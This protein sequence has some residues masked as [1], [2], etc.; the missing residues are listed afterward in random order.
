MFKAIA[1]LAGVFAAPISKVGQR[2]GHGPSIFRMGDEVRKSTSASTRWVAVTT[3]DVPPPGVKTWIFY[4]GGAT[5]IY[6]HGAVA[7][8]VVK[9]LDTKVGGPT[10]MLALVQ[11]P[12]NAITTGTYDQRS[13]VRAVRVNEE[14]MS[15]AFRPVRNLNRLSRKPQMYR[16]DVLRMNPPGCRH[17]NQSHTSA[18]SLGSVQTG[19]A[20]RNPMAATTSFTAPTSVCCYDAETGRLACPASSRVNGM[21]AELID[22]DASTARARVRMPDGRER[23]I[24]ICPS[25]GLAPGSGIPQDCCFDGVTSKVVCS[26]SMELNGQSATVTNE[27]QLDDG[28]RMAVVQLEDGSQLTIPLC[29]PTTQQPPV[30][31][32]VDED[33]MRLVCDDPDHPWNGVDVS[34]VSNC[35]DDPQTGTRMCFVDLGGDANVI[36]PAC[37]GPSYRTPPGG[38]Y[39]CPEGM[40]LDA[41]GNCAYKTPPP[42][43]GCPE[44]MQLDAM[45]NCVPNYTPPGY[46]PPS[47]PDG[48]VFDPMSNSCMPSYTPPPGGYQPPNYQPPPGQPCCESC[49][50]GGC[51]ECAGN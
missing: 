40:E 44:G 42:G 51:C 45:G 17:M 4:T 11:L 47:C 35:Y 29:R 13:V 6:H 38:G 41:A 28:T 48:Y 46:T 19:P 34:L 33:T 5:G 31:C 49:G 12:V 20:K 27:F 43:G 32:C 18:S 10:G 21:K 1:D 26:S 24:A 2:Y 15:L 50:R 22:I 8:I 16:I 37:S 39:E 30:S 23:S 3:F 25:N 9:V 14:S 36:L 7:G